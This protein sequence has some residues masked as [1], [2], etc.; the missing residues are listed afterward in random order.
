[1]PT[2]SF[3]SDT[4]F[5]FEKAMSSKFTSFLPSSH[6][7][8]YPASFEKENDGSY[9]VRFP[10]FDGCFTQGTSFELAFCNAVEALSL[11]IFGMLSDGEE[12][13]SPSS[14]TADCVLVSVPFPKELPSRI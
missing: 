13:P 10:D 2:N 14:A 12:L 6:F 9:S 11:H 8:T 4:P 7:Y 3:L 1:M 5:D